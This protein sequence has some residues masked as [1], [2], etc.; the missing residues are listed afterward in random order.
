MTRQMSCPYR[1]LPFYAGAPDAI[2][3]TARSSRNSQNDGLHDD[4]SVERT[5]D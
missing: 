2:E 5:A 4:C 3:A 1:D